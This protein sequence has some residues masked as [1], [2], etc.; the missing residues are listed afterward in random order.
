MKAIGKYQIIDEI[1]TGVAG[2]TFEDSAK[3][4][5]E[6]IVRRLLETAEPL[7]VD[8]ERLG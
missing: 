2:V 4:M 6:V 3:E 8:W 5:S 7:Q 1:G